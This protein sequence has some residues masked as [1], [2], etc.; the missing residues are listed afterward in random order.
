MPMGTVLY[1]AAP[2]VKDKANEEWVDQ[3]PAISHKKYYMVY[4]VIKTLQKSK[5]INTILQDL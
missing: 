5:N 2:Y 4:S 1:Q 3:N